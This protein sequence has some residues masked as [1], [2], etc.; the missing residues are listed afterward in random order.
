[1]YRPPKSGQPGAY[2]APNARK[3]GTDAQIHTGSNKDFP[4]L[5]KAADTQA[6]KKAPTI[7]FATLLK[8]KS[9]E[10]PDISGNI[11]EETDLKFRLIVD[12][13]DQPNE[14]EDEIDRLY[15]A[16]FKKLAAIRIA[17]QKKNENKKRQWLFESSSEEESPEETYSDEFWSEGEDNNNNNNNELEDAYDPSEFDRHR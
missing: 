1:M 11:I 2:V 14:K 9:E 13:P 7:S 8:K 17:A 16:P 12:M 15:F 5:A 6:V 3:E 4:V 10:K